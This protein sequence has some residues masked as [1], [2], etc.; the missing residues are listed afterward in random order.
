[1]SEFVRCKATATHGGRCWR[2]SHTMGKHLVLPPGK[3]PTLAQIERVIAAR[4]DMNRE[5][6]FRAVIAEQAVPDSTATEK[7]AWTSFDKMFER[8]ERTFK[9][10]DAM[11][12]GFSSPRK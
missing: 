6:V 2:G 11:F 7:D 8:L 10:M 1:M 12:D 5:V 4:P 3:A 9:K